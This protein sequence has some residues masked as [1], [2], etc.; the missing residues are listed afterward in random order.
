MK[1]ITRAFKC[2]CFSYMI[3]RLDLPSSGG[4]V[5]QNPE[6]PRIVDSEMTEER[7]EK[8]VRYLVRAEGSSRASTSG[9]NKIQNLCYDHHQSP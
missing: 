2:L 3:C 4:F 5:F 7:L 1:C 9:L 8:I 6:S